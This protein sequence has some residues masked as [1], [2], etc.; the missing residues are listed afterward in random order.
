MKRL[1]FENRDKV[2]L[3]YKNIIIKQPND[4]LNFK[5]FRFFIIVYKIL[6]FNYKLS[7]LK[8]MQIH[9]IFYISLFE[10]ILKSTEI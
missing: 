5:K 1:S 8:T 7:L 9:H 10:L 3:L 4:K 2:Y 6:E